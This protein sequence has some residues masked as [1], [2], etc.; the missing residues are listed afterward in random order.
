MQ[1]EMPWCSKSVQVRLKNDVTALQLEPP[2]W[3]SDNSG[4]A[5]TALAPVF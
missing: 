3:T 5:S 1:V 4:R 2:D